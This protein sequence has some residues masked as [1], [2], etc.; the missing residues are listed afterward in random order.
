M[1]ETT[2]YFWSGG[3]EFMDMLEKEGIDKLYHNAI[4]E[5]FSGVELR[6]DEWQRQ[7]NHL[8]G[9]TYEEIP[10]VWHLDYNGIINTYEDILPEMEE[11]GILEYY[12]IQFDDKNKVMVW[13]DWD[14]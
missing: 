13:Q 10:S 12:L 11:R 5:L 3:Q 8:R 14:Y 1:E 4:V 6:A 9:C 2:E 7:I